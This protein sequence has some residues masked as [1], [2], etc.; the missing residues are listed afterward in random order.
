MSWPPP[1]KSTND[2][3]S[4]VGKSRPGIAAEHGDGSALW[5]ELTK[6]AKAIG[7]RVEL[8]EPAEPITLIP[9][10]SFISCQA[11]LNCF[12]LTLITGIGSS[13]PL[14][15]RGTSPALAREVANNQVSTEMNMSKEQTVVTTEECFGGCPK[16]GQT[17]GYRNVGR[18]HWGACD[19]HKTCSPIGET[20]SPAGMTRLKRSGSATPGTRSLRG[21]KTNLSTGP[22][23]EEIEADRLAK[24]ARPKYSS[25]DD[26]AY[27][28]LIHGIEGPGCS[29][30]KLES[31]ERLSFADSIASAPFGCLM[32]PKR[33]L[34]RTR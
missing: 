4:N 17:N 14:E 18:N 13:R 2:K 16:C 27:M 20:F 23:P 11:V 10:L 32:A 6:L 9:G 24:A 31:S 34:S 15:G 21:R 19:T 29:Q 7:Y 1:W 25:E 28:E 5:A 22:R 12:L 33:K 8:E 3:R 30:H 26:E